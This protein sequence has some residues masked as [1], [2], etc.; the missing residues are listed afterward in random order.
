[1]ASLSQFELKKA[2]NNAALGVLY[3]HMK[4]NWMMAQLL[5]MGFALLALAGCKKGNG[6]GAGGSSVQP[7]APC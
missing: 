3:L 7:A 5:V 2:V 6:S 1:L 4:V